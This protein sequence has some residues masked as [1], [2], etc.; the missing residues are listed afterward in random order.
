[1]KRKG[2]GN[3]T[4]RPFRIWDEHEKGNAPHR[5]YSSAANAR[6]TALTIVDGAHVGRSYTVYNNDTADWVCTFTRR[7]HD[8]H[9]ADKRRNYALDGRK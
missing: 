7:V 6:H 9:Y 2:K 8:I 5:C 1:M 4:A 3:G